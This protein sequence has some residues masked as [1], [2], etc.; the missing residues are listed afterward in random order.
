VNDTSQ[1]LFFPVS[2]LYL[3]LNTLNSLLFCQNTP[4]YPR[5]QGRA[6]NGVPGHDL[7]FNWLMEVPDE[8]EFMFGGSD[9]GELMAYF[10]NLVCFW[11]F[12]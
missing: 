11:A 8:N 6:S 7:L 10:G 4:K 3:S 5:L 1:N 9:S 2:L 12:L